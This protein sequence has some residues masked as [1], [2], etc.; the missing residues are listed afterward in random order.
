[1]AIKLLWLAVP[2]A[3]ETSHWTVKVVVD[4]VDQFCRRPPRRDRLWR[5]VRALSSRG[6][7]LQGAGDVA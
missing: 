7:D 5:G 3:T 1:M 6:P 4:P 2:S